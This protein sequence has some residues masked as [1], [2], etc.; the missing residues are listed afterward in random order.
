MPGRTAALAS[1]WAEAEILQASRIRSS[2]EGS[3]RRRMR[4]STGQG[5][6]NASAARPV[7]GARSSCVA[8]AR[9]TSGSTSG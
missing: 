8:Q 3:L 7:R 4:C 6:T 2:S 1:S 5:A 9:S